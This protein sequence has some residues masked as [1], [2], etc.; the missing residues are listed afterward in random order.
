MPRS[1]CHAP[2]RHASDSTCHSVVESFEY[3]E[4]RGGKSPGLTAVQEHSL[5]NGF[6]KEAFSSWC[7]SFFVEDTNY[8]TPP[9]LGLLQI[10]VERG[11][12]TIVVG[13]DAAKIEKGPDFF[14]RGVVECEVGSV[15]LEGFKFSFPLLCSSGSMAAYRGVEMSVVESVSLQSTP[16]ALGEGY[17]A[18]L[19]DMNSII[20]GAL[21]EVRS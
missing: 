18:L 10:A 16:W 19:L 2:R 20:P 6:V 12:I 3:L 4:H 13:N 17:K 21:L 5:D 15:G 11:P 8:H 9:F 1:I 7:C 14:Y